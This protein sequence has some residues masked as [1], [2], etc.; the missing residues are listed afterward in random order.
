MWS[1]DVTWSIFGGTKFWE[2][3]T[4]WDSLNLFETL[5]L[6]APDPSRSKQI[7]E[8]RGDMTRA[9][10]SCTSGRAAS[11]ETSS[12]TLDRPMF[13]WTQMDRPR[14]SHGYGCHGRWFYDISRFSSSIFV[15]S[16]N[17]EHGWTLLTRF[18]CWHD[19]LSH[20]DLPCFWSDW[21]CLAAVWLNHWASLSLWVWALS[22]SMAVR[23]QV[24]I[25]FRPSVLLINSCGYPWFQTR[26]SRYQSEQSLT[27]PSSRNDTAVAK[28]WYVSFHQHFLFLFL[29]FFFFFWFEKIVWL[30]LGMQL[31]SA[32][33]AIDVSPGSQEC[34]LG[35]HAKGWNILRIPQDRHSIACEIWNYIAPWQ[36]LY[37]LIYLYTYK[38][39]IQN[40]FLFI[41]SPSQT[42]SCH[43][44]ARKSCKL[45][46]GFR[47]LKVAFVTGLQTAGPGLSGAPC[48]LCSELSN[49][50]ECRVLMGFGR[51]WSRWKK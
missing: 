2:V 26:L 29:R 49:R 8:T 44:L 31:S 15:H 51:A 41:I 24:S 48:V 43:C 33:C 9:L 23:A 10:S 25:N 3:E 47:F 50:I 40:I 45:D 7:Q 6:F 4:L 18:T 39:H 38:T 11:S 5:H 21:K 34:R 46:D 32:E 30:N 42:I 20:V 14:R 28:M 17:V 22:D 35:R 12:L 19:I 27:P 13:W 36:I 16:W 1:R 37:A